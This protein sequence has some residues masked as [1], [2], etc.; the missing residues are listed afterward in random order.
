VLRTS[1]H[2]PITRVELARTVF[3]R[4]LHWVSCYLI[5][6]TLIDTGPPATAR[7]MV[8]WCRERRIRQVV[9]TH[10]HEDH[11][12][13]DAAL[14]ADLGLPVAAP[15]ETARILAHFYRI[16]LYRR[17]VWGQPKSVKVAALGKTVETAHH[18]CLFDPVER[19]LVSGDL[20][21]SPR[22]RYLRE[23]EDAW[24]ILASLHRVRDL[25]PRTLLCSHAGVVENG[26]EALTRKIRDWEQLAGR[27]RVLRDRGVPERRITRQLLG[28]EGLMRLISLGDFSK[29]HLVRSLLREHASGGTPEGTSSPLAQ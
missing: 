8:R 11:A 24:T 22:A 16:P 25:H 2:G 27:A 26:E 19:W 15:A 1:H 20:Y 21:I 17:V 3:G 13:G 5:D 23:V 28:R 18:L 10:H 4:P 29:R 6:D 9:N 12:G 14:A 7:E